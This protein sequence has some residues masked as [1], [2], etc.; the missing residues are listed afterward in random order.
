MKKLNYGRIGTIFTLVGG[1][2]SIMASLAANKQYI[3]DMDAKIA[4]EVAK[5]INK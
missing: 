3:I 5:Q 2:L 1:G 4:E